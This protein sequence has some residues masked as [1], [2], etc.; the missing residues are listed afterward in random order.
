METNEIILIVT[1]MIFFSKGI[2]QTLGHES[3]KRAEHSG[4]TVVEEIFSDVY[5]RGGG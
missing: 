3:G 1:P 2:C 4:L 5:V